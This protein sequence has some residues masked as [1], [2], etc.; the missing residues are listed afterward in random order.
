MVPPIHRAGHYSTICKY[1]FHNTNVSKP[2]C[3]IDIGLEDYDG[4][5]DW[6]AGDMPAIFKCSIHPLKGIGVCSPRHKASMQLVVPLICPPSTL[7]IRKDVART[8]LQ[9]ARDRKS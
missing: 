7:S 1:L 3:A 4:T 5:K 8:P 9:H 2:I 6:G